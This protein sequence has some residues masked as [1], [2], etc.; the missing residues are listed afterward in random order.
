MYIE[1]CHQNKVNPSYGQ[2]LCMEQGLLDLENKIRKEPPVK[3]R[4][5]KWIWIIN[6]LFS[7]N[8]SFTQFN[9]QYSGEGCWQ[10][11]VIINA[12]LNSTIGRYCGRR[13]KWSAF[14]PAKP[15]VLQFF[16]FH[17]SKSTFEL[18]F[19]LSST[20][21]QT[22]IIYLE[23][24]KELVIGSK[25]YFPPFSKVNKYIV[26]DKYFY[27]WNIFVEKMFKLKLHVQK[28]PIYIKYLYLYDGPD[29][30]SKQYNIT[31]EKTVVFTS[32]QCSVLIQGSIYL[33]EIHLVFKKT[34]LRKDRIS[35]Q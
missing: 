7:L 30:N 16:T 32:F 6:D 19:Q 24:E 34:S 29:F 27:I 18:F 5:S 1:R 17:H 20:L 28:I 21:V 2:L 14:A 8:M 13:N 12:E 4:R 26:I 33:T 3:I 9:L 25:P 10:E 23:R 11:R 15:I 35:Q 22:E 31:V